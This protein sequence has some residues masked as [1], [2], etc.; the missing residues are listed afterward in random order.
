M[1]DAHTAQLYDDKERVLG[2]ENMRWLVRQ[3]LLKAVDDH[4]VR[5]LT[6]MED[7]RTG[8]GLQAVGQRD[9]LAV[10]RSEGRHNFVDMW[11]QIRR[12]V[13]HTLFHVTLS[14]SAPVAA[15]NG[16][17]SGNGPGDGA[18]VPAG[19]GMTAASGN[20]AMTASARRTAA[21]A[22]E[23]PMAAVNGG[24]GRGVATAVRPRASRKIG[25]NT[26]CPCGSGRKYKRCCGANA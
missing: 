11:R 13:T 10:Y 26:P 18:A 19:A 14:R 8:V 5:H 3:L 22:M 16:V 15:S 4:W 24:G 6:A 20:G 17:V 7:L 25:R 9:P 23:S 1:L 21:R 2:A 12:A